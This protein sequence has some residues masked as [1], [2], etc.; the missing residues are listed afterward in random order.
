MLFLQVFPIPFLCVDRISE[1]I[2]SQCQRTNLPFFEPIVNFDDNEQKKR[3]D[4]L[5]ELCSLGHKGPYL[6]IEVPNHYPASI[7]KNPAQRQSLYFGRTIACL[8]L[9]CL[10]RI[11]WKNCVLSYEREKQMVD[12]FKY[13][14]LAFDPFEPINGIENYEKKEK[15]EL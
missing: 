13:D 6:F 15:L 9:G 4:S 3:T 7:C 5:S 12:D 8:L 1:V 2:I 11:N 10:Q 14:F